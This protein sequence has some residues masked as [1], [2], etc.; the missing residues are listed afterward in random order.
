MQHCRVVLYSKVLHCTVLWR[1]ME[2][3]KV[4]TRSTV[5][6]CTIQ[7]REHRTNLLL[8]SAHPLQ[9]RFELHEALLVLGLAQLLH[10]GLGLFLGQLL[11]EVCQKTEQ[12]VSDHGVVSVL[13]VQLQDLHEVVEATLVLGVLAGLVHGEDVSLAQELGSLGLATTDLSDGLQGG[14]EVASTDEV[15]GIEGIDLAIALEVVHV[16]GE[17]DRV[18]FLLLKSELSHVCYMW[19]LSPAPVLAVLGVPM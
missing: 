14:V 5:L 4:S 8:S 9:E 11:S 17:F 18:N 7:V 19:P 15:A 3:L 12:L 2:G 16:E 13:V 10:Q 1:Q 6:Y